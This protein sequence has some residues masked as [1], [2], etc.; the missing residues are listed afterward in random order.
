MFAYI[1]IYIYIY[2]Y[3]Q[4]F[5]YIFICYY[6]DSKLE[7]IITYLFPR[8]ALYIIKCFIYNV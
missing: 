4:T 5:I 3:K 6:L 1:Y 2:I 8:C 7:R